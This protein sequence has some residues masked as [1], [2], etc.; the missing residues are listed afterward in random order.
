MLDINL[1]GLLYT[2]KLAVHFF[3][4]QN[5]SADQDHC[6]ILK[7]SL[8]GYLNLIGAPIYNATK[9]GVRG[10]MGNL[11]WT[12]WKDSIRVN[13]VAP[14]FIQTPII[15]KEDLEY[16]ESVGAEFALQE[17]AAN[18]MLRIASD[19]NL[20]GIAATIVD[21]SYS[22]LTNCCEGRSLAI[23]PR[24]WNSDGYVDV[25]HDDF[26]DGD[27]LQLWQKK[28]IAISQ[29]PVVCLFLNGL[30]FA[31]L[32][33]MSLGPYS[34]TNFGTK[35]SFGLSPSAR[36]NDLRSLV[37]SNTSNLKHYSILVNRNSMSIFK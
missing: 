16:L 28:I 13:V 18:A 12:S 7:S 5:L 14:W 27:P 10:L 8:A 32:I 25:D 2:T 19:G 31:V 4:K 21:S 33:P 35:Q 34:S 24:S 23:V 36:N 11:R 6:L 9:F 26:K 1:G 3:R 17:D 22:M 30:V 15:K 37:G 29:A 20:N